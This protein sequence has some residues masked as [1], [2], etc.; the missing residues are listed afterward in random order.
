MDICEKSVVDHIK[1][2]SQKKRG[3]RTKLYCRICHRFEHNMAD[4]FQYLANQQSTWEEET[5]K[6]G[7]DG[8]EGKV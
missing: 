2:L 1:E 3:R 5:D 4:C 7:E 8:Q 6:F